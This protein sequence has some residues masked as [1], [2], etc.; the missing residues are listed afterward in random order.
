MS[1]RELQTKRRKE[2]LDLLSVLFGGTRGR[3]HVSWVPMISGHG[4]RLIS[5]GQ[6]SGSGLSPAFLPLIPR[7]LSVSFEESWAE[8]RNSDPVLTCTRLV[9]HDARRDLKELFV[10]EAEPSCSQDD[11]HTG[12]K[13]GWHVHLKELPTPWRKLHLGMFPKDQLARREC[14]DVGERADLNAKMRRV[15]RMLWV[16]LVG[17]DW[18]EWKPT[19]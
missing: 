4:F 17:R 16:E 18:S 12:Y 2:V 13:R 7:T 3:A 11:A 19:G 8:P 14:F 5:V 15:L 9:I 6:G 1:L 10:L